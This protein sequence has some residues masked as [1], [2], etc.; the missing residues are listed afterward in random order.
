MERKVCARAEAKARQRKATQARRPV[1]GYSAN[2]I[3]IHGTQTYQPGNR[4]DDIH[5][6]VTRNFGLF[7]PSSGPQISTSAHDPHMPTPTH[8]RLENVLQ[9][10]GL[11]RVR[12]SGSVEKD[13]DEAHTAHYNTHIKQHVP[14]IRLNEA[15]SNSNTDPAAAIAYAI[16]NWGS[17]WRC[18]L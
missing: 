4:P 10:Q 2:D 1:D 9:P 13:P 18:N 6:L 14:Q 11:S 5:L 16:W 8:C 15:E 7:K 3:W 12:S 17:R